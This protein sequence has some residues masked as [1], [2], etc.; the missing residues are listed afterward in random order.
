MVE[1]MEMKLSSFLKAVSMSK[2]SFDRYA[3]R[4]EHPL[5]A[6]KRGGV[7]VVDISEYKQWRTEEDKRCRA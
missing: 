6:Y 4:A 5:P 1:V 2:R 3:H 7:W